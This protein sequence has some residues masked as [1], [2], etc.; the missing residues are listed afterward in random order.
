MR[1]RINQLRAARED[2]GFQQG[3]DHP[4]AAMSTHTHTHLSY[5]IS[6]FR[7]APEGQGLQRFR[8]PSAAASIQMSVAE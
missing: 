6:K 1:C 5:R 8:P 2:E 4:I 7:V 3:F